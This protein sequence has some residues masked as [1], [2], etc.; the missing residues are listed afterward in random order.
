AERFTYGPYGDVTVYDGSWNVRSASSYNWR[1]GFQGYRYEVVIG[2]YGAR[3]RDYDPVL[4]RFVQVDPLGYGAGDPDLYRLEGGDPVGGLDPT[5]LA[6]I[7]P[8]GRLVPGQH[9]QAQDQDRANLMALLNGRRPQRAA[10]ILAS[11]QAA[12]TAPSA[13]RP[14]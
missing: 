7:T 2:L 9:G 5:G 10:A 14:A 13:T 11:G 4:A 1:Y 6:A 12:T 8:D 3:G